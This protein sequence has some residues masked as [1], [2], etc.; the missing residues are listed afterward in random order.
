[1]ITHRIISSGGT[2]ISWLVQILGDFGWQNDV[3]CS[4]LQEARDRVA[5]L[6]NREPGDRALD[7]ERIDD[8]QRTWRRP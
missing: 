8:L 1:M 5:E 7:P 2:P 6:D 4:S 3:E